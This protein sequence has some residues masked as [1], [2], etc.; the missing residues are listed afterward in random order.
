MKVIK[1]DKTEMNNKEY[2]VMKNWMK[3]E[4]KE[5]EKSQGF[6]Y[7]EEWSSFV[8]F[9]KF[10]VMTRVTRNKLP[11]SGQALINKYEKTKGY[12]KY[13]M[14]LM[15]GKDATDVEYLIGLIDLA[16][17]SEIILKF[18]KMKGQ[19]MRM[20][21][22]K[23][24][25]IDKIIGKGDYDEIK[26]G[27]VVVIDGFKENWERFVS[28]KDWSFDYEVG[29]IAVTKYDWERNDEKKSGENNGKSKNNGENN[30]KNN[31]KSK[32]NGENNGKNNGKSKN[33]GEN[34]G[35]NKKNTGEK[36]KKTQGKKIKNGLKK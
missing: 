10:G 16:E 7:Y 31:G 5:W 36:N 28:K 17:H 11:N 3:T 4:N 6:R 35:K 19:K 25:V 18:Y 21:K 24:S 33:N 9:K 23:R 2:E 20:Y 27:D 34:N 8:P 29:V 1:V 32:N 26:Q 13:H 12:D 30:G 15:E 14:Y 22:S